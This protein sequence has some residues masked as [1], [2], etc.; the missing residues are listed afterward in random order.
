MKS[1]WRIKNIY[2]FL[3]QKLLFWFLWIRRS[4]L[5]VK[6]LCVI[7][8]RLHYGQLQR[9]YL[10]GLTGENCL[11][12]IRLGAQPVKC[13][14]RRQLQSRTQVLLVYNVLMCIC[15]T[16]PI[17]PFWRS[18]CWR[19]LAKVFL[20]HL[21]WHLLMGERWWVLKTLSSTLTQYSIIFPS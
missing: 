1:I 5:Q 7:F 17:A 11:P 8:F 20:R 14:L 4:W 15:I 6:I 18:P 16:S 9:F 10:A 2:V 21:C 3:F 12:H 13:T 19:H